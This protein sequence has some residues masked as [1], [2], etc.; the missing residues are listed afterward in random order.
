MLDSYGISDQVE[1]EYKE[2]YIL[3]KPLHNPR[4][5]WSALYEMSFE[6]EGFEEPSIPGEIGEEELPDYE[7]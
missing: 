6:K 4:K 2:G 7:D 1:I 5:N 3:I